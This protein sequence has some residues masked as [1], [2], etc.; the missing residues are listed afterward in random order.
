MT[1]ARSTTV[2]PL[3]SAWLRSS[4]GIHF[5]SR[6]KTGSWVGWPGSEPR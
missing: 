5:A 3:S 2:A 4:A 1:E 6:P